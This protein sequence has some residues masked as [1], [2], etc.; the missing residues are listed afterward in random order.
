MESYTYLFLFVLQLVFTVV[1]LLTLLHEKRL[2]KQQEKKNKQLLT[3]LSNLREE[4]Q[5]MTNTHFTFIG[6]IARISES[7]MTALAE[8]K[9]LISATEKLKKELERIKAAPSRNIKKLPVSRKQPLPVNPTLGSKARKKKR[10]QTGVAYG[11][12]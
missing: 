1:V 2:Q 11:R 9:K 7:T 4:I 10:L 5:A 3:E 8:L 12:S 6:K